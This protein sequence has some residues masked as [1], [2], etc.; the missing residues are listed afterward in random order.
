MPYWRL[1]AYYLCYFASLGAL[2]P[3]WALYLQAEGFDALAIGQLL[4][5]LSITKI[6]APIVWGHLVDRSG[7]RMPLVRLGALLAALTFLTV[8]IAHSFWSMAAAMLL[9][10]F[11]WNSSLPQVEAVTF[12]HL[13]AKSSRYALVRLWGSVGFIVIVTL[14]GWRLT[15]DAVTTL[16]IWLL[17]LFISVWL[18]SLLIPDS[19]PVHSEHATL[20]LRHILQQRTMIAFFAACFLMQLSH[21]IY[22]AFYSLHLKAAGYSSVAV[23]NLW[24]IGVF[25][26]VLIF[27]VT[28]RLLDHFGAR[29]VLLW[30]LAFAV[31]RWLLIGNFVAL[32]PVQI[33]AQLLHAVTF[34]T[35]HAAAIHFVH[36]AFSGRTQGRGQALYNSLSFGAGG[37]AGSLLG[38]FLWAD[39][40]ALMS[41][42]VGAAAT[43]I[44]FVIVWRGMKLDAA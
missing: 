29:R 28:P 4:A 27:L 13:Q 33:I 20:S 8:F 43:A 34:G 11:F 15:H 44:G 3:Y 30:S 22:Y 18:S 40:G 39:T 1:S 35:F 19:A 21:G 14:L 41:F 31:V 17:V 10:S 6:I 26:E 5:L 9:F 2:V 38:G 23:G 36:H 25:A 32:L 7:Q 16:P 24:A 12:N 37:A 42:G